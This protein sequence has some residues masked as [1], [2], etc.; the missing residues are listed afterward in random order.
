MLRRCA[1]EIC[2]AL[3][4]R[5]PQGASPPE[6]S[7][8]ARLA[9]VGASPPALFGWLLDYPVLYVFAEAGAATRGLGC[10]ALAKFEL[11]STLGTDALAGPAFTV[12]GAE[13]GSDRLRL[14]LDAWVARAEARVQAS[15]CGAT[16]LRCVMTTPQAACSLAF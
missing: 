14:C 13:A 12:P 16:G 2:A 3:R 4:G 8:A 7:C 9:H 11:V 10:T 6:V 1:R 15:S 5:A